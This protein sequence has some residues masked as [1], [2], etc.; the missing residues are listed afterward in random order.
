MKFG[1][2]YLSQ[3][4]GQMSKRCSDLYEDLGTN[5]L[6]LQ[7]KKPGRC[8]LLWRNYYPIISPLWGCITNM[9]QVYVPQRLLPSGCGNTGRMFLMVPPSPP[10]SPLVL[11]K[12]PYIQVPIDV[13]AWV[14]VLGLFRESTVLQGGKLCRCR[15]WVC[16]WT[17][18]GKTEMLP[19]YSL[20]LVFLTRVIAK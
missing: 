15:L 20:L 2:W 19:K 8:G 14:V 13:G 6:W 10:K 12:P 7:L 9:V 17:S 11:E 1:P 3:S 5:T 4:V 18:N 16:K